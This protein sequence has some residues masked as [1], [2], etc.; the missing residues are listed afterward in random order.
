MKF[1]NVILDYEK[2]LMA[3][4]QKLILRDNIYVYPVCYPNRGVFVKE[5]YKNAPGATMARGWYLETEPYDI[6][7]IDTFHDA[8]NGQFCWINGRAL[9]SIITNLTELSTYG[10][11]AVIDFDPVNDRDASIQRY[12]DIT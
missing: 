5:I 12:I 6:S 10:K 8:S 2:T 4:A 7:D 11:L 9:D 1:D 3:N